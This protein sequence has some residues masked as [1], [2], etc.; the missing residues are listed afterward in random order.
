MAAHDSS[1][2]DLVMDAVRNAQ[3]LVRTE[4]ALAKAEIRD[5][6]RRLG[7]GAGLLAGAAVA[8]LLALAFLL[9][10]VAWGLSEGLAMPVWAGFAVVTVVM[11]LASLVLGLMGRSRLAVARHMPK[12]LDTL[13]ENAEWIRARTS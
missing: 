1:I 9:T 11:L 10:T 7:V 5:E 2:A 6:G 13:K 12:T 3:V 8:G 4:I